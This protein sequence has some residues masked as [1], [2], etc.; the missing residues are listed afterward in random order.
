[1]NPFEM[2]RGF[3]IDLL[4]LPFVFKLGL[5]W[6]VGAA[7]WQW[8]KTRRQAQL[9][10]ASV[11][12]PLHRGEV[13][14]AQVITPRRHENDEDGPSSWEGLL[15]Y[16]YTLPGHELEIGEHRKRFFNQAQA[17]DWAL[18]LQ[19]KSVDVRVDPDDSKRSVWQETSVLY[20]PALPLASQADTG[21]WGLL[22]FVVLC[23]SCV[24]AV[25]AAWIQL[26]SLVGKP[27]MA[28]GGN[29]FGYF[30]M[31]HV[32]AMVCAVASNLVLSKGKLSGFKTQRELFEKGSAGARVMQALGLYYA[33][34]FL[35]G[36]VRS[37]SH[38]RESGGWSVLMFSAAWLLF[39][40]TSAVTCWR[41]IHERASS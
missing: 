14:A 26:G 1:M 29:S 30:G 22:A 37:S 7:G 41:G 8:W 23:V 21:L 32:G 3:L 9:V 19:D 13:V 24:G 12:W 38:A 35:Y 40:V 2:A 18:A 36:F 16:S 31:M 34:V 27:V 20:V 10:A 5:L 28:M 25:L 15:T 11:N 4:H 17:E 6:M 33:T 39:Y